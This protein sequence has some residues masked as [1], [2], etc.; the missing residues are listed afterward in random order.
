M[1][2]TADLLDKLYALFLYYLFRQYIML[3]ALLHSIY[4][5]PGAYVHPP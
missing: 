2:S 1:Q 5:G 4:V 3:Y